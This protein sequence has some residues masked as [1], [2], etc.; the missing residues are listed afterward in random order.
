MCNILMIALYTL[1]WTVRTV[2]EEIVA[3]TAGLLLKA[4][5]KVS[6]FGR[7]FSV[8]VCNMFFF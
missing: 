3:Q 1:V 2:S 6:G 7:N 4:V 8:T 5:K